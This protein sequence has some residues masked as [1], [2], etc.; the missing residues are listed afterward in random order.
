M[1]M[2]QCKTTYV[3]ETL[4]LDIDTDVCVLPVMSL[5]VCPNH[6]A[7]SLLIV[8]KIIHNYWT[9]THHNLLDCLLCLW[10]RL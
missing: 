7:T 5:S 6:T 10:T 9:I 2:V 8:I 1:D 4:K 3:R